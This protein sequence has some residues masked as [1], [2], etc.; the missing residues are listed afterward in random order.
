MRSLRL[1]GVLL[2]FLFASAASARAQTYLL[3][4]S[5]DALVGWLDNYNPGPPPTCDLTAA[6]GG[7]SVQCGLTALPGG[8][9]L[10]SVPGGSSIYLF[11]G[12]TALIANVPGYWVLD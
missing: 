2:A 5:E 6:G 10:V 4:T 1:V 8:V 7:P 9:I 3:Y 12:G 11:P